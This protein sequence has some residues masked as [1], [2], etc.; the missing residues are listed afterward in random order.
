MNNKFKILTYCGQ[1]MDVDMLEKGLYATTTPKLFDYDKTI[2]IIINEW[3]NLSERFG[4]DFTRCIENIKK[5]ELTSYELVELDSNINKSKIF[6]TGE[7]KEDDLMLLWI[8]RI[9]RIA[10]N[11]DDL[12]KFIER[13]INK[14]ESKDY[15]DRESKA[16]REPSKELYKI[17][18][19]YAEIYGICEA[20]I[21]TPFVIESYL[22]GSYRLTVNYSENET[23]IEKN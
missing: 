18:L 14:Y 8:E 21:I 19:A 4:L 10:K 15:L 1:F 6:F 20:S 13:V 2:E 3:Q 17:L 7:N 9:K 22:I 11:P 5:C 23:T 12:N 16:N